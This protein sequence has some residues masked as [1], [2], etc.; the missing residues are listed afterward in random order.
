MS[1]APKTMES[2]TAVGQTEH[3]KQSAPL[4]PKN[5]LKQFIPTP[6]ELREYRLMRMLGEWIFEPNLWHLNRYS[7]SMAFFVGLFVCFLPIPGQMAVAALL[8]LLFRCNLPLSAALVW[9]TNPVTMPAIFY[10]AYK[11]GAVLLDIP[12]QETSFELSLEWIRDSLATI[13]KPLLLG[14]VVCGLLF[15]SAGYFIINMAWRW[16]VARNWRKRKRARK[17]AARAKNS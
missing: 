9:I 11:V 16:R 7:A 2:S 5:T 4:M 6:Q 15:G 17:R 1:P 8:A 13:W 10:M 12:L 14:G 3:P